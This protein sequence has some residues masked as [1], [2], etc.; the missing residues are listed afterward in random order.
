MTKEEAVI[1]D[2]AY[3]AA[4]GKCWLARMMG[5]RVGNVVA[6]HPG[7]CSFCEFEP[8][9]LIGRIEEFLHWAGLNPID[10]IRIG[11]PILRPLRNQVES[12]QMLGD[13]EQKALVRKAQGHTPPKTDDVERPSDIWR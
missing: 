7:E 6:D 4:A 12:F 5:G 1:R 8:E 13:A 2:P 9:Y 11:E 3:A 10:E